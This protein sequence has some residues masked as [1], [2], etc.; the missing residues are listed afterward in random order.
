MKSKKGVFLVRK[1]SCTTFSRA[2]VQKIREK[3]GNI[4]KTWSMTKKRSSEILADKMEIFP[5]KIVILVCEQIFPSPP[6][7]AP[8]FRPCI[9]LSIPDLCFN[10]APKSCLTTG[11]VNTCKCNTDR[12]ITI[13][14]GLTFFFKIKS[15]KSIWEHFKKLLQNKD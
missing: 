1:G 10:G 4:R 9:Q 2:K 14:T 15:L 6:N 7:S 13:T 3:R 12:P 5:E 11:F 8:G